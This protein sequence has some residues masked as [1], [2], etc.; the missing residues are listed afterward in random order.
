MARLSEVF[1]GYCL[2][3]P[4]KGGERVFFRSEACPHSREENEGR[5][6]ENRIRNIVREEMARIMALP[7]RAL[8]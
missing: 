5:A 1:D 6:M 3:C 8:L 4:K 7:D 2:I